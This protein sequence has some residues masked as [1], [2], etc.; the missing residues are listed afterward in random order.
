MTT[1]ATLY[2]QLGEKLRALPGWSPSTNM[3]RGLAYSLR[4]EPAMTPIRSDLMGEEADLATA[5]LATM[6]AARRAQLQREWD[7]DPVGAP[8]EIV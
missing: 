8:R 2:E 7:A 4:I 3:P 5:H 6:S 1:T